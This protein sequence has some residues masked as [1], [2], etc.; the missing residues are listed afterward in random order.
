MAQSIDRR[1][2]R[3]RKALQGA[4]IALIT[5]KGY[6]AVTVQ[7]IIDEADVGRS[8]FYAHYTGKDDLLR[9]SFEQLRALLVDEQRDSAD[10]VRSKDAL[11]FSRAVFEH[12]CEY[13]HAYRALV[14]SRGGVVAANELR[15]IIGDAVRKELAPR[16]GASTVP[17]DVVV[18]FVVG[19]F[20]TVLSSSL[21]RRPAMPPAEMEKVFR[22]LALR[23]IGWL[24]E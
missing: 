21:R 6:E 24:I 15:R 7:D 1:A 18:Q 16:L 11:L 12:A 9:K 17:P 23:G 3:T 22:Q 14:G 8:T 20:L 5:R 2:A 13:R 10:Q 4:L 19:T